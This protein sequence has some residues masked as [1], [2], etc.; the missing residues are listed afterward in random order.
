MPRLAEDFRGFR[1]RPDMRKLD[2]LPVTWNHPKRSSLVK[3]APPEIAAVLFSVSTSFFFFFFFSSF[4]SLFV[5]RQLR[6]HCKWFITVR[7][8]RGYYAK[9]LSPRQNDRSAHIPFPFDVLYIWSVSLE[10]RNF[11]F[12]GNFLSLL[13]G[14]WRTFLGTL[15]A[16]F[17]GELLL[18]ILLCIGSIFFFHDYTKCDDRSHK[19]M[20]IN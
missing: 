19:Y 18:Y 2:A 16:G 10:F 15:A 17:L 7:E 5:K 11:A 6:G 3:I 4:S 1:R 8:R 12:R 14:G 20:V 9:N 13:G